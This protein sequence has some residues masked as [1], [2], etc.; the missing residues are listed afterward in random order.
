MDY[1]DVIIIKGP[2][3]TL[4]FFSERLA[5]T[6][7]TELDKRVIVW[8]M[9]NP[10]ESRLRIENIRETAVL[11]TFNFI[12]LSGESQFTVEGKDGRETSVWDYYGI[13]KVCIMVDNPLYY[14]DQLEIIDECKLYC[15]DRQHVNFIRRYY[16]GKKVDFLPLAGT[17]LGEIGTKRDIDVFFAGNYVNIA[18]LEDRIN[19]LDK[20][21][22]EFCY[23]M[24]EDLKTNTGKGMNEVIEEYVRA[25]IPD[26]SREDMLMVTNKMM[27]IDLYIRSYFRRKIICNIAE[28]GIKVHIIGKDWEK[29]GCKKPENLVLLGQR[30][31]L[32][33]LR[34]MKKSKVSVNIM[35]WFKDGVHDRFFNGMA[36]GSVVVSDSSRYIDEIAKDGV[37]YFKYSLDNI[38][39]IPDIVNSAVKRDDVAGQGCEL[40]CNGHLWRHRAMEI[41][42]NLKNNH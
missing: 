16:P 35:P 42:K 18:S 10:L 11:I 28:N 9:K 8:D 17:S 13:K 39:Y 5:E 32:E 3:E 1:T 19:M 15:I 38:S 22:R 27:V 2:V 30:D 24:I 20:D 25:D 14:K 12:G 4:S 21:N 6:F 36:Q 23:S 26:I 37:D 7:Y 33:C 31:S 34:Y 41:D 29:A 40:T